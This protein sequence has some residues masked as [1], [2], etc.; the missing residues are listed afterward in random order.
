MAWRDKHGDL[1]YGSKKDGAGT[2]WSSPAGKG[3]RESTRKNADGT[4]SHYR[5]EDGKIDGYHYNP[6][7][8]ASKK[9]EKKDHR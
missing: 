2:W 6:K 8:G 1:E 4:V 5:H 3:R 7:T 9:F